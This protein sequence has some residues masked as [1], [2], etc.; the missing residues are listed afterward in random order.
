MPAIVKKKDIMCRNLDQAD[1]L[2][3]LS[4]NINIVNNPIDF[5]KLELLFVNI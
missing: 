5:L 1:I 3:L 2:L 4:N